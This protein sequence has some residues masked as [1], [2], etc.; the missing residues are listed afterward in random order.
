MRGIYQRCGEHHLHRYLAEF[1]AITP[2]RS[3]A[4][5]IGIVRMKRWTASLV[6][7]W[8]RLSRLGAIVILSLP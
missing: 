4:S 8:Q 3:W 1:S 7:A 2:A 6:R 5:T